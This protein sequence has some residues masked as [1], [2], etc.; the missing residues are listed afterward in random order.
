MLGKNIAALAMEIF[1]G[2]MHTIII[3][4]ITIQSS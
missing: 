4:T 1:Q 2:Q 3:K